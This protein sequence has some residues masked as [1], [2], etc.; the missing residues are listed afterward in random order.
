MLADS[1]LGYVYG[2][3]QNPSDHGTLWWNLRMF[4]T[5]RPSIATR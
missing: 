3:C 1:G 2:Q 5:K 4:P